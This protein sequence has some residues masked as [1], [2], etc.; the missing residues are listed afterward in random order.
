MKKS[1]LARLAEYMRRGLRSYSIDC[2]TSF[3]Y[4]IQ[5][6]RYYITA[7]FEHTYIISFRCRER[8]YLLPLDWDICIFQ[9]N[10]L[11]NLYDL[12]LQRRNITCEVVYDDPDDQHIYGT[13]YG[14]KYF[15]SL[16]PYSIIVHR[17]ITHR[18]DHDEERI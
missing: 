4:V 9:Q 16:D 14:P 18:D 12:S 13:K 15:L 8:R 17:K 3:G 6:S 7:G 11:N 1:A 5:Y 10:D 2:S